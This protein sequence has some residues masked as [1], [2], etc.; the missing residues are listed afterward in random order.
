MTFAMLRPK[1]LSLHRW[2]GLVF[3]PVF[4]VMILSGAVLSFRPI[5]A[6]VGSSERAASAETLV[7]VAAVT[8]LVGKLEASG[9][10]TGITVSGGGKAL[11]VA[12]ATPSVAGTWTLADGTRAAEAAAPFDVFGLAERIHKSLALGLGLVVEA[13]SFAMLSIMII[14]PLLSLLR[15]RNSL[16]G[17]HR[18]AGWLAFPVTII[19]PLTAVMMVLGIGEGARAPLPVAAQKVTIAEALAIAAP[20][21]DL[22]HLEM[23]RTF[24]G[25]TVMLTTS[26]A[27]G[28]TYAVTDTAAVP[29]TGGPG[30]V[31]EIH[32]G[33]W[34]GAWSGALN[35]I[36]SMVLFA[37]TVTGFIAWFRRWRR[38]R[39]PARLTGGGDVLVAYA[40]QT[41]TAA[42]LATAAAKTLEAA[43]LSADVASLGTLEPA[44]LAIYRH[45]LVIAATTGE[46][47]VPDAARR[48]VKALVPGALTGTSFAM[49]ALGDRSY[50]HYC[51][52]AETLRAAMLTA[53]AEE[54]QPM[55]R[56]DGEP[57]AT[58]AEWM[59]AVS[60]LL[61]LSGAG[62]A[63]PESGTPVVLRLAAR[64]RMDDPASGETQETWSVTLVSDA[65]LAFRPGDLLR[66]APTEGAKLR[67]Y[68]V[69]SA[70]AV[71]P[72]RIELTVR[73]HQWED[74]DGQTGFGAMSG[75]LIRDLAVGDM[76]A[77]R[78]DAHPAFNPPADPSWPIIMIG[79]GSGIAPFPGFVSERR[80]TGRAGPAWLVF[81]NRYRDGDFLWSE[82]F[83]AA[84]ADGSLTRLDGAFS[85]DEGDGAYVQTRLRQSAATLADWIITRQAVIYICGK[86]DMADGVL[87]AIEQSL[88]AANA[89]DARD[90]I[91]RWIGEGRIRIDVFD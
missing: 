13:A 4:L 12:S 8:S 54:A 33:T 35:F 25:G 82:H 37:L 40:S 87:G 69:G 73:L 43:G 38:E 76:V 57:G 5:L 9:S 49:L 51:G 36:I 71:D 62:I 27:K 1:L 58:F 60:T 55:A 16:I 41:G 91:E 68:S 2:L 85:R 22:G 45:T 79:A 24:R 67:A 63:E 14:G 83:A 6:D 20:A 18:A 74:R 90:R 11:D 7:D 64:H 15:F 10:I 3:A 34:A 78:L 66:I 65:A 89:T 80:A 70:S 88:V 26:G 81:G 47:D 48:F 19:A 50:A 53:G 29:L 30:L 86:R 28:G 44:R 32:E 72:H 31:K 21:A 75:R 23:A 17:W 77:A 42:R 61:G 59:A 52:G 56:T 46:G 84:L 39:K